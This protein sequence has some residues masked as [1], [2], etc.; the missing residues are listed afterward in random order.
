MPGDT[1]A[2][3][4]K[5]LG[6][7]ERLLWSGQPKQGLTFR[8]SDWF[9]I[10]FSLLWCGFAIY[11]ESSVISTVG[12]DFFA[13][14]GIPFVLMGLYLVVGRFF[15]DAQQ[16]ARTTYALTD[17]RVIIVSGLSARNVRS[18]DLKTLAEMEL[19]TQ[20]G[21]R[22]TIAFGQSY[23]MARWYSGVPWPGMDRYLAPAFEMIE[24][25]KEVHDLIRKA[26]QE[27]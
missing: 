3:I 19:T 13:L 18:L 8:P 22:G 27:M 24:N 7:N 16:R 23:P 5:E 9:Q 26:R 12:L 10:P 2:L 11:W 15:A 1:T 4:R 17:E 25:A 6:P 20:G 21:S 14:W